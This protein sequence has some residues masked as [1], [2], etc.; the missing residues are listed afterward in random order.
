MRI[1]FEEWKRSQKRFE[2]L[3]SNISIGP[4]V[5]DRPC[6]H[7]QCSNCKGTGFNARGEACVH[8]LACPCPRCSAYC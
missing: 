8:G 6:L 7:L 5:P 4:R 3:M 2:D 1:D